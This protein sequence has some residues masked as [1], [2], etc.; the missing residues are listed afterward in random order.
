[1]NYKHSPLVWA[2][3]KTGSNDLNKLIK[4][5]LDYENDQLAKVFVNEAE[6]DE[7]IFEV[8]E[9]SNEDKQMVLDKEGIS[10]GSYSHEA[11]E[12]AIRNIE[13][14][15]GQNYSLEKICKKIETNPVAVSD[16]LKDSNVLP[17]RRVND[18]AKDFLF[19]VVREVLQEDDD[20]IAPLVEFAGE[21]ILQKR[22]VDK[23][24]EKGFSTAQVSNYR[25]ILGKDINDYLM[26]GFFPNLC[27]RL[28]LFMYLPKTPFI[29]HLSAGV[30]GSFEVFIFIY[31]WSRDKLFRLRSVYV[32]KRES[33][34]K[35]RLIDLQNDDS[36]PAQAEKE[37]IQL[38]L[39]E[40][41]EFKSKIDEI[42]QSGYDPK[43]D[44][45]VG[46]NIAPLQ[47]KGLLKTEVLKTN[48]L[49]KYLEAD[50]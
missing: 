12:D 4:T 2:K 7:L 14:L 18:I 6:I 49:K 30:K 23:L 32:E 31:K 15:Y 28:N 36:I 13:E 8:Y 45:G 41:G 20:G 3:E 1:M 43:L 34:L 24:V 16:I 39:E 9:L 50:W 5:Y 25:D 26:G 22:L 17:E 42:L 38:Q 27:D 33:S 11:N 46:K 10:I 35:N 48:Q 21:E 37:K 47:E 44:D 19:D 29:W 40:I